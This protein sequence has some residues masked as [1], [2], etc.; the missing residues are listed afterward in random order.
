VELLRGFRR[1]WPAVELVLRE[2]PPQEQIDALKNGRLDVGFVRAPI[3]DPQIAWRI[4]RHEELVVVLPDTHRL[5]RRK[6]IDLSMLASEPFVSFPRERSPAFFDRLVRLCSDAGFTPRVVQEAPQLDLVS[7]VAVG[8]GVALVPSSMRAARRPG[9]A[10]R[11]IVGAPRADLLVAWRRTADE[12]LERAPILREF[13]AT[14][15]RVGTRG[16]RARK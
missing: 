5:A 12:A 2:L 13:L 11:R 1:R 4:V 15:Q 8:F 6:T 10:L 14:A 3:E 16:N 9:V 7:L